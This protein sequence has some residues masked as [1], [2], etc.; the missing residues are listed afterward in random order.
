MLTGETVG[1]QVRVVVPPDR[2]VQ[3]G[4]TLHFRPRSGHIVWMDPASGVAIAR[5]E[6]RNIGLS[7]AGN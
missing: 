3:V 7:A 4:E 2:P 1:Q 6:A 5:D